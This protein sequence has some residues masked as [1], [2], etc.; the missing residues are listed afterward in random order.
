MFKERLHMNVPVLQLGEFV[1]KFILKS[2]HLTLML[3]NY[4]PGTSPEQYLGIKANHREAIN[5]K[6]NKGKYMHLKVIH[7]F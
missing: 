4:N 3:A 6:S 5:T 2:T 7:P 1:I